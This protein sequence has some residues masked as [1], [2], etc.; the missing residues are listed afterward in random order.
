MA[1]IR[2]RRTK[3]GTRYTVL[4]D[5]EDENGTRK[6]KSAGTFKSKKDAETAVLDIDLKKRRN[7]FINP[8]M[9]TVGEFINRWLTIRAKLK[10]W[11][12]S[13]LQTATG[14]L[15]NHVIPEIGELYIQ[16]VTPMH[17]DCMFS[18]LQEKRCSGPKSYNMDEEQVPYLSG[19]TLGS[20]YTLV[21]CFFE[22]AVTWKLIEENPVILEKPRRNEHDDMK[23]WDLCTTKIAL[24]NITHEQLHLM[25]HIASVL[26]CRNGEICGLTWDVINLDKGMLKI[27]RT[28]QRVDKKVYDKLPKKEVFL[29][30]P[31]KVEDSK[32]F[33]V[34]KTPK[35]SG[36]IRYLCLTQPIIE[37]L[38]RRK[39][40]V[41]KN[42]LYYGDNYTDNNLVFCQDD[43]T[44]VEPNLL[45]KWFRLWQLRNPDL[46]LPF[47]KFHGLRHSA[48]TL[49]MYL[50][51]SDAKT[52]QTIT[53]HTS[54]KLVF[55]VYNHP[56]M[57]NQKLLI[58]KLERVMYEKSTQGD[59]IPETLQ[60]STDDILR[61]LR[62]NPLLHQE[63]ISA[64]RAEVAADAANSTNIAC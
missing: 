6:Q 12:F 29:I 27:D 7:K 26:T 47:I 11:E 58:E 24:A 18:H 35:T 1:S 25:V 62:K 52:V 31:N 17:I 53:G 56:L 45:E 50:S 48:T 20:I 61:T 23:I 10:E 9:E 5:F 51:G 46:G 57:E 32:S 8:S 2:K 36:S 3:E 37:E 42:M 16:D 14:L 21:K 41:A 33:L 39:Q 44:P 64:L 22:A 59:L 38:K 63:V 60:L 34:L 15:E 13:Y 4:F 28:M 19:S 49:L 40:Q 43:G 54:A 30:F 55:D